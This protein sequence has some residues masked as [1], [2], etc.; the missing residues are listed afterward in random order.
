MNG[1]RRIEPARSRTVSCLLP[2]PPSSPNHSWLS[3]KN[4]SPAMI[5]NGGRRRRDPNSFISFSVQSIM[6]PTTSDLVTQQRDSGSE[7]RQPNPKIHQIRPAPTPSPISHNL[8]ATTV[9]KSGK[10]HGF[11]TVSIHPIRLAASSS[12]CAGGSIERHDSSNPFGS[13]SLAAAAFSSIPAGENPPPLPLAA[14]EPSRCHASTQPPHA[15]LV[16]NPPAR[17]AMNALVTISEFT[18]CRLIGV[19][20]NGRGARSETAVLKK[21]WVTPIPK[22]PSNKPIQGHTVWGRFMSFPVD[23]RGSLTLNAQGSETTSTADF[24]GEFLCSEMEGLSVYTFVLD[25]VTI[26]RK[27]VLLFIRL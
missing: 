13:H 21:P 6:K 20:S 7:I 26:Q 25:L 1:V 15:S 10:I 11:S 9:Q 24:D 17:D 4:P 12:P 23:R 8:A 16:E 19:G 5:P 3:T 22:T 18:W 27:S 14:G 2:A